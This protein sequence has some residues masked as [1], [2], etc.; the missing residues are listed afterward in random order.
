[1]N[2]PRADANRSIAE[3]LKVGRRYLGGALPT[4]PET[5]PPNFGLAPEQEDRALALHREAVVIDM[6]TE[7]D[8]TGSFFADIAEGGL[9]CGSFTIGAGGR[10]GRAHTTEEWYVNDRR[11]L[12]HGYTLRERPSSNGSR[13]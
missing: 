1:M 6:L 11:G 9:T 7:S 10:A 8:Y 13:C 4:V 2:A 5:T 12:E 3:V